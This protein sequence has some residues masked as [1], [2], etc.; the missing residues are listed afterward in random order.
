MYTCRCLPG[1]AASPAQAGGSPCCTSLP[2]YHTIYHCLI[3]LCPFSSPQDLLPHLHKLVGEQA[4]AAV[5]P[6]Q[7]RGAALINALHGGTRSGLPAVRQAMG[8]LLWHCNQVLMQQL[9]AWWVKR[10]V[11]RE[12]NRRAAKWKGRFHA[13]VRGTGRVA[14]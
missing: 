14:W 13:V 11:A 9:A 1:P 8:R 4:A 7:Q 12:G 6:L 5:G 3:A 2:R 10:P